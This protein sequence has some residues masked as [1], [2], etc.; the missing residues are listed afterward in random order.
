MYM[1]D[2]IFWIGVVLWST[3]IVIWF[4]ASKASYSEFFVLSILILTGG[5]I[6]MLFVISFLYGVISII[7]LK[8]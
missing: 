4:Y 3:T 8:A 6:I 7:G 5:M 1:I 2:Y